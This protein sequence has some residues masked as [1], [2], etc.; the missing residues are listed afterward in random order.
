MLIIVLM[1]SIIGVIVWSRGCLIIWLRKVGKITVIKWL[2]RVIG[3]VR[4]TGVVGVVRLARVARVA[5]V[6]GSL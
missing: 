4:V 2:V 6:V 1:R 5:R 3:V